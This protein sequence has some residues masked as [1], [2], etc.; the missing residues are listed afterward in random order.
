MARLAR[1]A[2]V[3]GRLRGESLRQDRELDGL[4]VFTEKAR[5]VALAI[6]VIRIDLDPSCVASAAHESVEQAHA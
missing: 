1:R 2:R 4:S 6:R 5:V 3:D